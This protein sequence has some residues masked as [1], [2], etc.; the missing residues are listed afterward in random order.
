MHLSKQTLRRGLIFLAVIKSATGCTVDIISPAPAPAPAKRT[1]D[2]FVHRSDTVQVK[3][4]LTGDQYLWALTRAYGAAPYPQYEPMKKVSDGKWSA[5]LQ[6]GDAKIKRGLL[7]E[8]NVLVVD[9]AANRDLM[10]EKSNKRVLFESP[11]SVCNHT[12]TVRLA[13]D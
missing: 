4:D 7:L 12:L 1:P 3:A 5:Q 8:L 10:S 9:S 2:I 6:F 13:L 11:K